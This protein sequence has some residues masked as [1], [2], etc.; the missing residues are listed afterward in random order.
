MEKVKFQKTVACIK[1]HANILLRGFGRTMYGVLIAGLIGSAIYG[2]ITIANES[3][4][5]AV[6]DFIASTATL[7][8]AL[9]NM[10]CLGKKRGGKK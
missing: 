10:Y 1:F 4:Y 6:C 8:V 5:A 7:L 3:G 9:C 2:Y